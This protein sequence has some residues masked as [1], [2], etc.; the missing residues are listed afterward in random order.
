MKVK[1]LNLDNLNQQMDKQSDGV[2]DFIEEVTA[3]S[4]NGRVIFRSKI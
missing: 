2:F 4:S 1:L 3:K